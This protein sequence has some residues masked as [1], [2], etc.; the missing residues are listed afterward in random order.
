MTRTET[1][2]AAIA[3]E[4]ERRRRWLDATADL[5]SLAIVLKMNSATGQVRAVIISTEVKAS[6]P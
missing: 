3:A 4:L 5:G 1:V 6:A 2:A